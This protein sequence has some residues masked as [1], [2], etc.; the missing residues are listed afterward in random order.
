MKYPFRDALRKTCSGNMWQIY[1]RPP[2]KKCDFRK[3]AKQL[4]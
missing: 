1:R 2:M 3:V 4:Y